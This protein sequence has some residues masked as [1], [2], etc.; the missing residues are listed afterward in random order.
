MNDYCRGVSQFDK[1]SRYAAMGL[2]FLLKCYLIDTTSEPGLS[3]TLYV[4][5]VGHY[6]TFLTTLR[7]HHPRR[8]YGLILCDVPAA[9]GWSTLGLPT[10]VAYLY[11]Q[12]KWSKEQHNDLSHHILA[13]EL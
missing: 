1:Y 7:E 9:A 11:S 6:Y 3:L 10:T 2:E 5:F 12:F 8:R 13:S 4:I